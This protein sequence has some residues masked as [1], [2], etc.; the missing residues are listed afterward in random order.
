MGD[1]DGDGV[2]EA[3]IF[4][5]FNVSDGTATALTVCKTKTQPDGSITL[6]PGTPVTLAYSVSDE[7]QA[8]VVDVDGDGARDVVFLAGA[9]GV[10]PRRSS[11]CGIKE[12]RIDPSRSPTI[13]QDESPEGFALVEDRAGK[14]PAMVYVTPTSVSLVHVDGR[15]T[16]DHRQLQ[17]LTAGTGGPPLPT[18]STATACRTSPSPIRRT[19]CCS[20]GRRCCRDACS[21]RAFTTSG[22]R[23]ARSSRSRRPSRRSRGGREQAKAVEQ[24]KMLFNAGAQ[25]YGGAGQFMAAVQAF[26]EAYKLRAAAGDLVLAIRN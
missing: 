25:A 10:R 23:A 9:I 14:L 11:C 15:V 12:G 20:M 17:A 22:G 1:I 24:A 26:E 6:E 16:S 18:S 7:G 8:A 13:A 19:S 4:T 5:P 3:L 21:P 2:D